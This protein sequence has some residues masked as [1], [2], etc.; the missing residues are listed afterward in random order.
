M[1]I[2]I[3]HREPE[4]FRTLFA[5]DDVV[6]TAQLEHGDFQVD[7]K[8]V[9]ERKTIKDLCVSLV[10]GRLF[11]QAVALLQCDGHPVYI[12]EGS[13][14]QLQDAGVR[15]EAVQGALITL[16]VFFGLPVLRSLDPEETVRLIRYTALQGVRF[17][18][19][20]VQ[21]FGYRPKGKKARQLFVLQ[22]LPGV[23]KKRAEALLNHFGGIE[24]VMS[25]SEEDL[26][27]VNGIGAP[28][29]EKIRNLV[30][31]AAVPYETTKD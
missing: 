28:I 2:V 8:W 30:R 6:T 12:L 10:D 15:R 4:L 24:A 27:E 20:G 17:A 13:S 19:G 23:G 16:S 25:A 14:H 22:G 11:R 3:D 21:R 18:E 7:Q 26:A 9:F 5:A 1:H 31:E 29:A